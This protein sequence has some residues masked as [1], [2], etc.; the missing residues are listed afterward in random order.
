M[1]KSDKDSGSFIQLTDPADVIEKKIRKAVTDFNSH[2]TYDPENRPGVATLIDIDSA[3]TG[4]E[5]EEIEEDCMLRALNTGDYKLEVAEKLVEHLKP[6]Q[7]E[8]MRLMSDKAHL[9]K[10]LKQGADKANEIAAYNY[11][12]V[13]KIIGMD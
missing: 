2:V 4:L 10:I 9:N 8:Y 11:G 1:S 6:I 12:N 5:P 13:C 7:S 3:C